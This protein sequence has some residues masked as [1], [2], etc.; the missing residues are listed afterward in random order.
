MRHLDNM[1]KILLATGLI[2]CY[3]YLMEAFMAWY[4]ASTFERFMMDNR[5]FGPYQHT[6]V[7]LILFNCLTVQI[8][9]YRPFRINAYVLWLVAL[10]VNIGMWLERYV[11]VVTS[12]HRDFVPA[13]WG[14]YHGTRW[15][16]FTYY[17]TIGLFFALMF[18]FI[19]VLPVISITEMRELVAETQERAPHSATSS[20]T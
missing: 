7:M 18:L 15:D 9:W 14:M 1:G 4:S 20:S 19:R 8:L 6:Y 3:G 12:L 16:Y 11:I 13:A 17:G 10:I 5:L 2:V